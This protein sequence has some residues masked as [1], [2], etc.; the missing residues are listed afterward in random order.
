MVPRGMRLIFYVLASLF[1]SLL[2][3]QSNLYQAPS[4]DSTAIHVVKSNIYSI[5]K[6]KK[7]V[8]GNTPKEG[9]TLPTS[10]IKSVRRFLF[11]VGFS[12]SGQHIIANLLDLHSHIVIAHGYSLFLQWNQDPQLH[13]DKT[14]LFNALVM[15]SWNHYYKLKAKRPSKKYTRTR[16]G[17]WQGQFY[18][19]I[20]V[21]GDNSG[22]FTTQL[23]GRNRTL[24]KMV[25]KEVKRT[26]KMPVHAIYIIENPFDAIATISLYSNK[27]SPNTSI[28]FYNN[29]NLK[30]AVLK[31][32]I[33]LKIVV[34]MI[35]KTPLNVL[36]LHIEDLILSP[37]YT[38]RQVCSFLHIECSNAYLQLCANS[39]ISS[40]PITRDAVHWSKDNIELVQRNIRKFRFLSRYISTVK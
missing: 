2:L 10:V 25:Y 20:Q 35:R 38:T 1:L 26:L 36:K 16:S 14:R 21:I 28:K 30:K 29:T 37:K 7:T 39:I 15:N 40:E 17:G 24:F 33:Q 5:S 23:F 8:S 3:L 19:K 9:K 6:E 31:Y 13:G 12:E 18:K 11:F 4:Q 27:I 32:F 34:E 22:G